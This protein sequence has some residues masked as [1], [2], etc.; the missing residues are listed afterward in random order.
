MRWRGKYLGSEERER[1]TGNWGVGSGQ[2]GRRGE[3][4]TGNWELDEDCEFVIFDLTS[5]V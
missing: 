2:W 4:G 3:S 5:A 1:G